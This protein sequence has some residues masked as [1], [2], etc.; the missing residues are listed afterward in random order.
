VL[1]FEY[2]GEIFMEVV[3]EGL[4]VEEFLEVM[5]F[6][7]GRDADVVITLDDGRSYCFRAGVSARENL[8]LR[9]RGCGCTVTYNVG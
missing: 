1:V 7:K 5:Y 8:E 2:F 6:N 9:V 3:Q 4:G